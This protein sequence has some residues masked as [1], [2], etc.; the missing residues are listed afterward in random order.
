MRMVSVRRLSGEPDSSVR[1]LGG[2]S[3]FREGQN[4]AVVR[5]RMLLQLADGHRGEWAG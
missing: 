1:S 4:L 3:E 5:Q 2:S